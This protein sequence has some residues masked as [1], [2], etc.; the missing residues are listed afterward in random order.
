MMLAVPIVYKNVLPST[1]SLKDIKDQYQHMLLKAKKDLDAMIAA[2]QAK[3]M[4]I[5][6][7]IEEGPQEKEILNAV[8]KQKIDFLV[9][10]AHEEGCLEQALFG[11]LN[12]EIHR[13]L[14]CSILFIKQKPGSA[15]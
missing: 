11:R 15:R 4:P 2:E 1:P 8:K 7:C 6:V 5:E 9:T 3:R 10:L 14:L 12:E 13:R